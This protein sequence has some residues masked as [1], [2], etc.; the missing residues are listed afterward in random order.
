MKNY[1]SIW[2]SGGRVGEV[3]SGRKTG[4]YVAFCLLADKAV[5]V[6]FFTLDLFPCMKHG[7][8]VFWSCI[9]WTKKER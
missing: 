8:C 2:K 9:L 3:K 7:T 5:N 4:E 1:P 6:F